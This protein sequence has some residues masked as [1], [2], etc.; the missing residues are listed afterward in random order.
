LSKP[1]VLTLAVL[2]GACGFTP[3]GDA[4]RTA[5]REV[6]TQASNEGLRNAA[7][8]LCNITTYGAINRVY[9]LGS[10]KRKALDEFC[11]GESEGNDE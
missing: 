3:Q 1:I 8:A 4:I 7:W 2:L 5:V 11:L 10:K 6:G 9:P